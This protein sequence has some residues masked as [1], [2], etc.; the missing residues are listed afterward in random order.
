MNV[1]I[2]REGKSELSTISSAKLTKK[3]EDQFHKSK[4]F[5][6]VGGL[7]TRLRSVVSDV[8]KPMAPIDGK[9]FLYY[10]L[11]QIKKMGMKNIVFCSGY[12][13]DIIESYFKDGSEFGLHIEYSVEKELMGTGGAIKNAEKYID[14]PFFMMNG[15]VYINV[16]LPYL[17]SYSSKKKAKHVMV[18]KPLGSY[19]AGGIVVTDPLMRIIQF[20]EK[21]SVDV[22]EKMPSPFINAGVYLLNPDILDMIPPNQNVSIEKQVFQKIADP[23][24][25]FYGMRYEDYFIDIGVPE[26]Y[27]QFIDDVKNKKIM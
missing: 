8:P 18:L 1:L 10:K 13:H 19:I 6:L 3:E 12:M 25:P 15:D 5:I 4:V 22:I 11:M 7:G 23:T 9:P 16:D 21:P 14:G 20:L 2:K 17:W 27:K 26:N 24:Y